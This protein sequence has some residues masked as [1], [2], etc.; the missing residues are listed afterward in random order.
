MR[1]RLIGVLLFAVLLMV[2]GCGDS[3]ANKIDGTW[4]INMEA[5]LDS[6]PELKATMGDSPK[7]MEMLTGMLG[8][9]TIIID[10]TKSTVSGKMAGVKLPEEDF[11]ILSEED[12]VV[13]IKDASGREMEFNIV[14]E[15]TI[16]INGPNGTTIV[17]N[18]K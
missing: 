5:T 8:D 10:V 2:S 7:A 12:D 15:N 3:S 16:S 9:S 6:S 1:M 17:L 13:T 4:T 14:D 18:R 11:T